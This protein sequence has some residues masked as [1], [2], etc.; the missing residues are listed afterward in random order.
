[1]K[2]LL[3][4]CWMLM[5]IAS[6]LAQA[7]NFSAQVGSN[8]LYFTITDANSKTVKVMYPANHNWNGY[9]Q[10]TGNLVIPSTVSNGGVT[11]SVTAIESDAFRSCSGLTSV[12]IPNTITTIGS[13]AFESCSGITSVSIPNSVTYIGI[14]AFAG[15]SSLTSVNIP[16]TVTFLGGAAFT[17]C[18]SLASVTL[19]NAIDTIRRNTFA[20][21]RNL[22]S[23]SIPASVK[24][25]MEYAFQYCSGLTTITIPN[26]VITIE[27]AAFKNDSSLT[28]VTIPNSVTYMG[29][30]VFESCTGLTS[31]TI[32]NSVTYLGS[33]AFEDCISL[34]SV[35]IP[36]KLATIERWTFYNCKSL[37]SVIIPN[38]VKSI[39]ADAFNNCRSLTSVDIPKSVTYIDYRAFKYCKSLTSVTI[40]DAVTYVGT[41]AFG[42][43]TG[44]T[45]IYWNADS[46]FAGYNNISAFDSC[47]KISNFI[48]GNHI[49]YIPSYIC[50]EL[51]SLT[52]VTI[53]NS[54][55]CIGRDAFWGCKGIASY[56][57]IPD[58]VTEI[59]NFAF[60]G[61]TNIPFFMFK[62][63]TPPEFG[64]ASFSVS[65]FYVPCGS[66]DLYAEKFF[67]DETI[68]ELSNIFSV[69]SDDNN[70]GWILISKYPSC[71][72]MNAVIEAVPKTNYY[73]FDHWSD[74]NT[75]NPRSLYVTG[76]TS[77]VAYFTKKTSISELE[78]SKVKIY[79]SGNS[80]VIELAHAQKYENE[81]VTVYD[82]LGR[83]IAKGRLGGSTLRL[84]VQPSGVYIVKINGLMPYK[85]VVQ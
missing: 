79:A 23:V 11:Y 80:I 58:S 84:T 76:D 60:S 63:P 82:V 75:D 46:A 64:D 48:F 2:R 3:I 57:V 47:T 85:V 5:Q 21:C 19:S 42:S 78:D 68:I 55:T 50:R 14:S 20:Y 69:V 52:S 26:S 8:T 39:G 71:S 22:T 35:T 70:K 15:D 28:S 17:N 81:P 40:P 30:A 67:N 18:I 25:I 38:S 62:R 51:P 13:S 37:T 56:V 6:V 74:G 10:P 53:P 4:F 27:N 9:T 33:S 45:T 83:E 43:C 29:N 1:M 7:W 24:V 41:S 65:L 77:L 54:V 36:N 34:L 61:C 49:R 44:L 73:R 31:I 12:T 32:P 16:N 72:D 66:L 59:G